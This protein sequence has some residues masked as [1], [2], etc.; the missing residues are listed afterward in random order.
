MCDPQTGKLDKMKILK[1]LFGSDSL[2]PNWQDF[3]DMKA[4][5]KWFFGMGERPHNLT[6]G[7]IGKNLTI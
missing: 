7:L 5:F 2:M 4:H 3:K 6:A 1:A